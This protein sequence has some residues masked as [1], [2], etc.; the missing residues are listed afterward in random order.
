VP[1]EIFINPPE[2]IRTYFTDDHAAGRPVTAHMLATGHVVL[3]RGAELQELRREA[4]AWLERRSYFSEAMAV[5]AR[6]FAATRYED[7]TDVANQDPA[8]A[9]MLLAPA[10]TEMLEL[11]YRARVGTVPRGKDLL[12][13]VA[14]LDPDL[15]TM[16]RRVFSDAPFA[17]RQVT[18]AEVADR[19]IGVRGFFEWDSGTEPVIAP[20][21]QAPNASAP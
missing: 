10:V 2:A 7:A 4:A 8:T 11:W 6:Y 9:T 16:A 14:D 5:R 19:T 13:R 17:E 20:P 12:A 1:A 15:A 18:A 3:A 21:K